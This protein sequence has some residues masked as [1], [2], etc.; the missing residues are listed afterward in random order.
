[1]AN[2]L[3]FL[4]IFS[5]HI[6]PT[7][8]LSSYLMNICLKYRSVLVDSCVFSL[9][10]SL[11]QVAVHELGHS[12]GLDH[13]EYYAAVMYPFYKAEM[14]GEVQLNYDDVEAMHKMYGQLVR[15]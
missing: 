14:S 12:L 7:N 9:G 10:T 13:S 2:V 15:E 4:L 5:E 1:M 3:E 8:D 11:F 6:K